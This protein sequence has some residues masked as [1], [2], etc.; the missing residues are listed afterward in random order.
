M[1]RKIVWS[2]PLQGL[3]LPE[4]FPKTAMWGGLSV[5]FLNAM[6]PL[7]AEAVWGEKT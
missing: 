4:T 7:K 1:E 6:V 3:I 2:R 5:S